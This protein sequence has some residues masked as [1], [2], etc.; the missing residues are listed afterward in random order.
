MTTA[1]NIKGQTEEKI[2][3]LY[4][5]LSVDDEKKDAESNS[6]TN[7]KQ[8]LLDYCQKQGF[9]N[10]MFF[11]DDGISGTSFERGGFQ[12]MQK[13]VEEGKICRVI[14]KD[15]SRFGRE[16]VEAGRLTQIVYP[17]LGVT[18]ISL[19]ENV[20][21]TTGEGMEMLPFYNIFNEWYAAQTSKKIRAVWQSKAENG[22]R[23]SP[24]VPF[25]Y[26][27]DLNDK[28]KWLIDEPAAE[29]VR[30]IYAL[31]LAGRGPLQIAKQ[32]EK[33]NILVPS[34]YYESV[35]RTH[36]QKVPSDY[37]K[38][39]QKTVVGILENRQY[40]GCAV[41]FKSTTVSYK[42]HKKIH[43]AKEDYQ[44]IPNM[45][46]PI[47]SE[48]QWL[49]VQE[50]RKHRRRPTA[51]GRTSLFSGLVYCADCGAKMHFAAAKSLT[52]NQEH[53]R[54]SNYKSGRGECTVHY[55]RDVVLEKI[56]FEAISSLA[57]FVKCHESVFLHMLAKKTNAMRQKE[58]KRLELAVE[59][60]TKRIA[61]ID[62][63]IEKV[64]EQNASGIL[65]DERFSK[66]LQSY[67]KEQKALTQEVADSRQTLEEAK[68]KATD[69]RLLLRTLRE[70]TEINE[71]TPTLV[72]SLIERIEVHNNDKS[73]GHCYVK[74]DIYFTAVGMI[75]IPTEQKIL[76]MMEEIQTNPQ[77]FR[78]VA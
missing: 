41:N 16:M 44:I 52:R 12:Q 2:T 17:S 59:Q 48:E 31:C 32:L 40:T 58:H 18:F 54:C 14:V 43:N 28:E 39:D 30:K 1:N 62:R 4:C 25:G 10:T 38:W 71:L 74:V 61:E 24:T 22:K 19:H 11:V 73:S 33:E 55:I 42:V 56:V 47:I 50:L 7:Q 27:K 3:A 23:V 77:D 63:L 46:E 65:S 26:V 37:C 5:R 13:M 45:Q 20:N 76:A 57:D 29:V 70:M 66:M 51:T 9:T 68:Q 53:F 6:I 15:L 34:A 21:S 78:F 60:G 36:A 35:G 8:I 69:L 67:E 49:R 72:N 75:D 64:F